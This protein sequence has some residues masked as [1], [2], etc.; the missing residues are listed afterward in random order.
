MA[1]I[2]EEDDVARDF[3]RAIYAMPM[4]LDIVRDNDTEKTKTVFEKYRP[5]WSDEKWRSAE[6]LVSGIEYATIM[7]RESRTPLPLQISDGLDAILTIY[8]VPEELRRQKIKKVLNMDYRALGRRILAEFREYLQKTN[9]EALRTAEK[10]TKRNP[11]KD[12]K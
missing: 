4:A 6:N 9:D 11:W 3:F 12:Y 8:G 7:T 1:A 10:R 2:C 5:D